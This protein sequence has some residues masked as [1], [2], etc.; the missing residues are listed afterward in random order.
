MSQSVGRQMHCNPALPQILYSHNFPFAQPATFC[1]ILLFCS[2][3][4]VIT[5]DSFALILLERPVSPASPGATQTPSSPQAAD[6]TCFT[7]LSRPSTG[8]ALRLAV[9]NSVRTTATWCAPRSRRV[10]VDW[11]VRSVALRHE[12]SSRTRDIDSLQLHQRKEAPGTANTIETRNG[13]V[14]VQVTWIGA[15]DGV[16]QQ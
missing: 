15:D 1:T 8:H 2:F 16:Q 3:A 10:T 12:V 4:S 14:D 5:T 13:A 6:S 9:C 7:A 11:I